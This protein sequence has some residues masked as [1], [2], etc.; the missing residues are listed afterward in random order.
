MQHATPTAVAEQ[1]LWQEIGETLANDSTRH[2]LVLKRLQCLDD[3]FDAAIAVLAVL[4]EEL[5]ERSQALLWSWANEQAARH[6][7]RG[8]KLDCLLQLKQQQ[9]LSCESVK[10]QALSPNCSGDECS[11]DGAES[12]NGADNTGGTSTR[13][14]VR[15]TRV[16][17]ACGSDTDS[18]GGARQRGS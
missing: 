12:L 10:H 8:D 4:P 18:D 11:Q 7:R 15:D 17:S 6:K 9:Q 1:M 5:C 3:P 14:H 13:V 2:N 16:S